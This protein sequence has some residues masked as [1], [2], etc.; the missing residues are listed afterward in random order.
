M[1]DAQG[2][3]VFSTPPTNGSII[4]IDYIEYDVPVRFDTDSLN[5]SYDDFRQLN[6]SIPLIEVLV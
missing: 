1:L 6:M 5:V 4:R 3:I 2:Q